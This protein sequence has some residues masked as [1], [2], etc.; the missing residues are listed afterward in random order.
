VHERTIGNLL[1]SS[2]I[3]PPDSVSE[4]DP[5]ELKSNQ[6]RGPGRR[7]L[8]QNPMNQKTDSLP[9]IYLARQ[10]ETAWS[11]TGRQTGLTDLPLTERGECNAR[12]LGD[13]LKGLAFVKVL[14][15]PL[16]RARRTCELAGFGAV[17]EVDRALVE[18]VQRPHGQDAK[19]KTPT[20]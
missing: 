12:R 11:I 6:C 8:G 16:Q 5:D 9:I 18:W 15:N 14:T 4:F 20:I 10:G 19:R 7:E 1:P 2:L 17:A 13:R 3:S